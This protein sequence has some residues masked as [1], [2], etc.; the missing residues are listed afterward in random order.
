[1]LLNFNLFDNLSDGVVILSKER[2]VVYFNKSAKEFFPDIYINKSCHGFYNIC[3]NCPMEI[4]KDENRNINVYDVHL[5]NKRVCFSMNP[6]FV[7]NEFYGVVEVFR[8]VSRVVHY[9]EDVHRQKE[10]TEKIFNSIVEGIIVT[11]KSGNVLNLN[12]SAK[13]LLCN[14]D[15]KQVIGTPVENIIGLTLEQMPVVDK[16]ADVY[17]QTSCGKLKASLMVST[18]RDEGYIISFYILPEQNIFYGFSENEFYTKSPKLA[19]TVEMAKYIAE[20][21][22]NVLIEGETG[23]GKTLLA[24]YIHFLSPRRNKSFVKVNCA[25]IPENLLESE[26]FGYVKGAF[27]GAVKDK[28]GKVELAH[29][30]TLFLDEIGDM[31]ISIQAKI[32]NLIQEKEIERLG[33]LSPIKVDVRIIAATNKDL[34]HLI[35]NKMFRE[36]LYY[37][38]NVVNIVLPPLRER[39]E[40]IPLLVKG[41]MEKFS[42]L[43]KKHVKHV[44]PE[45][46]RL[47]LKYDYPGNVRELENIIEHAV[48]MARNN[49]IEVRDLPDFLSYN[50][51]DTLLENLSEKEL[52]IKT[53]KQVN[54]NKVE[55]AKILNM[56]RTTLWRKIKEYGIEI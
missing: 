11:D 8:D 27:T 44:K 26:L 53:L 42:E 36:D 54:G 37:R 3:K 5:S 33:G 45:A 50:N 24:K 16:R 28:I 25:A 35:R 47:L 40:D 52:I 30:G 19:K 15:A 9:M 51:F 56:H 1:M 43:H 7:E 6:I 55:A 38:L 2:K 13:R 22:V 29:E 10:F 41:F 31:P 32:L 49:Y 46:M 14:L 48:I 12:E 34:K 39:K 18:L 23:T 4:A 21:N 20:H 17:I